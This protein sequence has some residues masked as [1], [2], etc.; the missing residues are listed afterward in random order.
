MRIQTTQ[1]KQVQSIPNFSSTQKDAFRCL[2]KARLSIWQVSLGPE[3]IRSE[4][5]GEVKAY[6]DEATQDSKSFWRMIKGFRRYLRSGTRFDVEDGSIRF[7]NSKDAWCRKPSKD[8]GL[9]LDL[10]KRLL[11]RKKMWD[12]KKSD[13]FQQFINVLEGMASMSTR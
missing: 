2:A 9:F 7:C 1:N 10:L 3:A 13:K 4:K 11:N 12:N 5:M 8:A 6:L